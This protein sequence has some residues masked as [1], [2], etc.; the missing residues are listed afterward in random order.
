[1]NARYDWYLSSS[2]NETLCCCGFSCKLLFTVSLL[3]VSTKIWQREDAQCVCHGAQSKSAGACMRGGYHM[4]PDGRSER[5]HRTFNG[6][7][8]GKG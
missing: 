7:I 4:E 8:K 3:V 5:K 6:C 2:I 1:M